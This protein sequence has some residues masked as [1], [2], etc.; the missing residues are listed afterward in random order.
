MSIN[1]FR[2]VCVLGWLSYGFDLINFLWTTS[3]WLVTLATASNSGWTGLERS[4][5]VLF[6]VGIGASLYPCCFVGSRGGDRVDAFSAPTSPT[7]TGPQSGIG[8]A[9]ADGGGDGQQSTAAGQ[10]Q[11]TILRNPLRGSKC[12][13]FWRFCANFV[14]YP[15]LYLFLWKFIL[16]LPCR[17]A[18]FCIFS[19]L[20]CLWWSFYA[21]W[22]VFL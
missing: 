18:L 11:T 9:M 16:L 12:N 6:T 15:F 8:V 14:P 3:G 22:D 2:F 5:D 21:T 20:L 17:G 13:C 7:S 4:C 19:T 1:N 10:Q